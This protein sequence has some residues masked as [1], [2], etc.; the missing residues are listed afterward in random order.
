[1]NSPPILVIGALAVTSAIPLFVWAIIGAPRSSRSLVRRN[2]GATRPRDAREAALELPAMQRAIRPAIKALA[3]RGRRLTPAGW[4]DSLERKLRLAG[5]PAAWP[6]DRVLAAKLV[7]ALTGAILAISVLASGF[8]V[9]GVLVAATAVVLG[10]FAPDAI[11]WGRAQERQQQIQRLLPDTLDQMTISVE[12]GLGF[13]AALK[14][15]ADT[16]EGPLSHELRRTLGELQLGVNRSDAFRHLADRTTVPELRHFVFAVQQAAEYGLPIAQVLRV[17][18]AELRV[19]RRQRA[20]AMAMKIPVKLV[21][22]LVFCIFPS[23]F[24]VL[25]VP[26]VMRITEVLF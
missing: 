22:P 21:F 26:A 10:Y 16:T 11:V 2:L 20:E 25:L 15:T 14:R 19:K 1:M 13:N 8:T 18:S 17:Q 9:L 4:V 23:L 6:L 3:A 12:A 24:I 5:E 7:L